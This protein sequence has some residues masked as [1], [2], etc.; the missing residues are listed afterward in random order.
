MSTTRK[1]R[2]S[3]LGLAGAVALVGT[4]IGCAP[5]SDSGGN[6]GEGA[7]DGGPTTVVLG[8]IGGQGDK[9]DPYHTSS[10]TA[11]DEARYRQV[12]E[13]LTWKQPDGSIANWLAESLEPN[14]DFTEWTV[15]LK[16]V[17]A[18]N[19]EKLVAQDV[20][21]T[22]QYV[23]DPANN[24]N[25]SSLVLLDADSMEAVDEKTVIMHLTEPYGPMDV[26][27]EGYAIIK[28]DGDELVGTG[29]FVPVS[30]TPGQN[31]VYETFDEYWGVGPEFDRLE[32]RSFS[33]QTSIANALRAGQ[34]DIAGTLPYA[35]SV[36]FIDQ[37]GF[38]VLESPNSAK[39]VTMEM[40][41][42]LA[43]FD[44]PRVREA[45]KLIIDRE[46]VAEVAYQGYAEPS[47]DFAHDSDHCPDP[48]LTREQDI[49]RAMQLLEE[50]G[51]PGLEV[52]YSYTTAAPGGEEMAE[53]FAQN[54]AEAG[55]TVK[56]DFMDEPTFLSQWGQWPFA[57]NYWQYPLVNSATSSMRADHPFNTTRWANEEFNELSAQLQRTA[58]ADEQCT[59]L[60][61]MKE[62]Q[63]TD[64]GFID[65]VSVTTL[66]AHSD[67][68]KG[69]QPSVWDDAFFRF[70]G[71]SV[72]Q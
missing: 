9:L 25:T 37:P 6:G 44:D 57:I 66:N 17:T 62:L 70:A 23:M 11:A 63:H 67:R 5:P 8:H 15:T 27:L 13:P 22:F 51:V 58:D 29:P 14:E 10:P 59:I 31:A 21:D 50:A 16:D 72:E 54:A 46:T 19:G 49:E 35:D 12:W 56:L 48:A 55:V 68:V 65:P 2:R 61:R 3:I 60:D 64:A 4:L 30:F 38:E 47:G 34:I 52:T 36:S 28:F 24:F 42:D 18:H 39:Q 26:F 40:R 7:G 41:V 43:P 69:L 33:D 53:L 45:F 1:M 20:V 32:I 71:V